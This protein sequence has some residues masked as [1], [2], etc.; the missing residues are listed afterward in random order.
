MALVH[1]HARSLCLYSATFSGKQKIPQASF[2]TTRADCGADLDSRVKTLG[3]LIRDEYANIRAV[4]GG[5]LIPLG[6]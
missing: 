4:Y 1:R 6:I 2:T 5:V 3:H